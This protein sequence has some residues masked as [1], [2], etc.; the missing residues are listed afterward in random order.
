MH[1]SG[2]GSVTIAQ[3]KG[4]KGHL[5]VQVEPS[6]KAASVSALRDMPGRTATDLCVLR[7]VE[8]QKEEELVI[9]LWVCVCA[10]KTGLALTA[11]FLGILTT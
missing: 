4:K 5:C 2:C 9:Y 1:L 10:L 8:L 7:I 6:V 11:L 3:M